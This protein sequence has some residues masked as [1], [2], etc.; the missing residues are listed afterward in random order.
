MAKYDLQK[1]LARIEQGESFEYL[2]FYGHAVNKDGSITDTCLSQWYPARF[3]IDGVSYKTAEH[4]MMAQKATVFN[5]DDSLQKIL[6]APTPAEAKS[7]G[8]KVQNF[9]SKE[10]QTKSFDIVVKANEAKFG[11]NPELGKWLL[12][13]APKVLVEASP[14]D[15][16]W[17]IGLGR[18]EKEAQDAR[19]WRGDNMLGFA[20][21]AARD[22]LTK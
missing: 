5:D 2:L 19:Q 7:R 15:R 12:A 1:L 9:D 4:Y 16:I 14:Y 20:L 10:W 18:D 8:R 11:Q 6:Q 17:G 13:T 21:M 22:L 3:T